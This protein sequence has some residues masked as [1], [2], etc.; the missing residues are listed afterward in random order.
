MA[1]KEN[2]LRREVAHLATPQDVR[3]A[4]NFNRALRVRKKR[5]ACERR[6][7]RPALNSIVIEC[8]YASAFPAGHV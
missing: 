8:A 7:L 4:I 3:V 5:W 6:P 2:D 1:E